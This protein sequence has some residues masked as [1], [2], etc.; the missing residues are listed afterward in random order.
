[1]RVLSK[2]NPP[3]RDREDNEAL[4]EGLRSGVISCVGT[5]HAECATKHKQEF[6]SAIVGFSGVQTLL[7]VMLSEGV[8]KGRI[9]LEKLV[10]VTS[11]NNARTFGLLPKK[12]TLDVGADADLVIVDLDKKATLSARDLYHLSDFCVYEGMEVKGGPVLTM[13]RGQVVMEDGEIV[14]KNPMGQ[15]LPIK[16]QA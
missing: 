8:N 13:V 12:G 1:H 16:P 7:P 3:L 15:F 9:T 5:D 2:V 4:W 10:E 11:Y 6:W 14:R